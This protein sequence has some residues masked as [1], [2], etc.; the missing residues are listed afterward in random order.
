MFIDDIIYDI[1]CLQKR[2]KAQNVHRSIFTRNYKILYFE[3]SAEK[4]LIWFMV[5]KALTYHLKY[6]SSENVI[7][8]CREVQNV[9]TLQ[10]NTYFCL[11]GNHP[12]TLKVTQSVNK[13]HGLYFQYTCPPEKNWQ[14]NLIGRSVPYDWQIRWVYW[15]TMKLKIESVIV[16]IQGMFGLQW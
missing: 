14:C 3:I 7:T 9:Q 5:N 11:A 8:K 6:Y 4:F 15:E 10:T 12:G 1:T 13:S 16:C 2:P